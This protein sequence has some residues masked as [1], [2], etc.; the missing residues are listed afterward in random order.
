[1]YQKGGVVA[2]GRNKNAIGNDELENL[3]WFFFSGEK[4]IFYV[5]SALYTF[6]KDI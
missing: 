4:E 6:E 2:G 5:L 1:M 3:L